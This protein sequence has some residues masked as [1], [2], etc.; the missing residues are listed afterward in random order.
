MRHA[1]RALPPW[2]L[3]GGGVSV[4]DSE[5]TPVSAPAHATRLDEGVVG[6]PATMDNM[7]SDGVLPGAKLLRATPHDER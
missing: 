4:S 1:S 5:R 6:N 2:Y 3:N 7:P